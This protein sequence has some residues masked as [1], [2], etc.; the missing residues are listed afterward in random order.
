MHFVSFC[1]FFSPL[2]ILLLTLSLSSPITLLFPCNSAS[3][4]ENVSTL[5]SILYAGFLSTLLLTFLWRLQ[6]DMH[7]AEDYLNPV[8]SSDRRS[9]YS[10]S[11]VVVFVFTIVAMADG[12]IRVVIKWLTR[13]DFAFLAVGGKGKSAAASKRKHQLA[14]IAAGRA[15]S[16]FLSGHY[17]SAPRTGGGCCVRCC[18]TICC[19]SCF[20]CCWKIRARVAIFLL[21]IKYRYV[22]VCFCFFFF[23]LVVCTLI[24]IF[25]SFLV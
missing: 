8:A 18:R 17:E 6:V 20:E 7:R 21:W 1:L 2:N 16:A 24:L 25:F 23:F 9:N 12:F 4:F 14:K 11:F 3:C 15:R 5:F 19:P 22:I 13:D 10:K